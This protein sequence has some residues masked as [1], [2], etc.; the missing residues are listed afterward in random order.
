MILL[1][2]TK[3][4]SLK[5]MCSVLYMN[6]CVRVYMSLYIDFFSALKMYYLY[7]NLQ[8]MFKGFHAFAVLCQRMM[9]RL[10]EEKELLA[11]LVGCYFSPTVVSAMIFFQCFWRWGLLA[12]DPWVSVIS[13]FFFFNKKRMRKIFRLLLSTHSVQECQAKIEGAG[14]D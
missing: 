1:N 12:R 4:I 9:G 10:D 3:P 5:T 11:Q 7:T 13:F 2:V 14:V 8:W 6:G